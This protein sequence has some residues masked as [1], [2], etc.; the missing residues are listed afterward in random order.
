MTMDAMQRGRDG[1]PGR[2]GFYGEAIVEFNEED[3]IWV[4]I[5]PHV[6]ELLETVRV[7][8]DLVKEIS[9]RHNK[10]EKS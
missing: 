6:V 10:G 2:A 8:L 1:G 5:R 4:P 3:G 7:A 9:D